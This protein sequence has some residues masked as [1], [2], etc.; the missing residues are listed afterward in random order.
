MVQL[1][2]NLH[3]KHDHIIPPIPRCL[4]ATNIT[5]HSNVQQDRHVPQGPRTLGHLALHDGPTVDVP[6]HPAPLI[7][8]KLIRHGSSVHIWNSRAQHTMLLRF[9]VLTPV[10]AGMVLMV[11]VPRFRNVNLAICRPRKWLLGQ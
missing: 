8:R 3:G 7:P 4:A 10:Q 1:P 2:S 6:N 11:A 9:M 5:A